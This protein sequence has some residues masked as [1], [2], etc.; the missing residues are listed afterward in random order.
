MTQLFQR[1]LFVLQDKTLRLQLTRFILTGFSG[2]FTDMFVYRLLVA[3]H[4]HVTPAKALGCVSGTVL[5]YFINRAWTFSGQ[6][7]SWSQMVRFSLLYGTS[8]FINTGLNTL[9]LHLLPHPWQV[10]FVFAAGVTTVINFLGSKFLVFRP[11][12]SAIEEAA[13]VAVEATPVELA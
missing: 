7:S 9:G 2:L 10:S 11:T 5:V 3:L 13:S 12:H 4:V 8:L 6:P 1:L